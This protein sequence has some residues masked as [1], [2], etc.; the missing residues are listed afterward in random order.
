MKKSEKLR[1]C[2]WSLVYVSALMLLSSIQL[3]A[4]SG[5]S[6]AWV[7]VHIIIGLIFTGLVF[8]H[9][10]LHFGTD[11][12]LWLRR[13]KKLKSPVTKVLCIL[14]LLTLISAIIAFAHWLGDFTHSSIGGVHGKIGFLMIIVAVGHILKRISFFQKRRPKQEV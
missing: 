9:V 3:E 10:A 4:T 1:L 8:W 14:F 12:G 5:E 7:T 13:F 2:N 6:V 11:T